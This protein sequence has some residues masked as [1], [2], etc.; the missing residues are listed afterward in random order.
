MKLCLTIMTPG[1]Q[2]GSSQGGF[3]RTAGESQV[4]QVITEWRLNVSG[5]TLYMRPTF[6]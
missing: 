6:M 5:T 4:T 1:G 2:L 3:D